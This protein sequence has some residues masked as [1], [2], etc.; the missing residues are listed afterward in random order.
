MNTMLVIG[1]GLLILYFACLAKVAMDEELRGT[2]YSTS[3]LVISL[4][5]LATSVCTTVYLVLN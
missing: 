5:F 3:N 1:N 4:V 2:E